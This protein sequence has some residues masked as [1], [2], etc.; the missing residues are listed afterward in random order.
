MNN[1]TPQPQARPDLSQD[2]TEAKTE[3][4]SETATTGDMSAVPFAPATPPDP[5]GGGNDEIPFLSYSRPSFWPDT[6]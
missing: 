2:E 6:F 4:G 1:P 3:T 5:D